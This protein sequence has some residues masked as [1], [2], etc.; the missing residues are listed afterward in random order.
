[1]DEKTVRETQDLVL[2]TVRQGRL[3][4]QDW[5]DAGVVPQ[6]S[7]KRL[8]LDLLSQLNDRQRIDEMDEDRMTL[9]EAQIKRFTNAYREGLGDRALRQEVDTAHL[10]D[11]TAINL[12]N[13][14]WRLR[15]FRGAKRALD[16]KLAA[17]R[18]TERLLS[19]V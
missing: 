4:A 7:T 1:M 10:S 15:Q 3:L 6:G 2:E 19:Q 16:D 18:E 13:L 14:S 11:V 5:Q 8:T 9:I 12:V 17:I